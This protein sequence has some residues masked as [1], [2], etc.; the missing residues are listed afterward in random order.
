MIG[1]ILQEFVPR[2]V[3]DCEILYIGDTG[4]KTI[5]F[6]EKVF[7]DL[8]VILHERGKLP[9]VVVYNRKKNW[10]FLIESVTSVGP[11]DDKRYWE[12]VDLFKGSKVGLVFVTVFPDRKRFS[13]FVNSISWETEV[14]IRDDPDH[15]VHFNGDRFLGPH[16]IPE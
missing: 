8:G 5:I 15:L 13:K 16:K 3:G 10:M 14:W 1:D 7:E 6:E 11:V 4:D 2:F 9:D 12:L